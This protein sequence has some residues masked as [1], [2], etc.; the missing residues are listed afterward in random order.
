MGGW[1]VRRG[2]WKEEDKGQG[3]DNRTP[4]V[5]MYDTGRYLDII[6]TDT[7]RHQ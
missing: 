7:D 1:C 5:N 4:Y 3:T 2:D 6:H